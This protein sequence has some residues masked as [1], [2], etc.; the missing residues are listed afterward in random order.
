MGLYTSKFKPLYSI[1]LHSIKPSGYR[2]KTKSDKDTL[3]IKQDSYLTKVLNFYIDYDLQPWQKKFCL[4]I[5]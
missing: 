1:F 4:K 3:A 5:L 2:M